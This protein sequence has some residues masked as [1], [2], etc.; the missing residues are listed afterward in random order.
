MIPGLEPIPLRDLQALGAI[1]HWMIEGSLEDLTSLTPV[2]GNLQAEHLG[3]ILALKGRFQT[4]VTLCCDRCLG[5]FN[6]QL[7]ADVEEII[8]LGELDNEA[9]L[10]AAG[11]NSDVRQGLVECLDPRGSFDPERWV[12]EQLSLE[13][14]VVNRCGSDCPGMPPGRGP[15]SDQERLHG[16]EPLDPRWQAL[17]ELSREER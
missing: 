5:Q 12:Y 3:N 7:I 11:L 6:H 8:W 14:P 9:A 13:L 4:I 15:G 17:R 16:A 1:K 2:R 10:T